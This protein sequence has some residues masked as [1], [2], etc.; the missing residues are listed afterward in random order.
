[1]LVM[2]F[3]LVDILGKALSL[4]HVQRGEEE[5]GGGSHEGLHVGWHQ[6]SKLIS[7]ERPNSGSD[8]RCVSE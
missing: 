8:A 7:L 6:T 3:F 5:K 2:V 1:M 4:V